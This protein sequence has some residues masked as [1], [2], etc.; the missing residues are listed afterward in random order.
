[1]PVCS[2]V[3]SLESP[4]PTARAFSP[5]TLTSIDYSLNPKIIAANPPAD[6][7]IER[8]GK[9]VDYDLPTLRGM[10]KANVNLGWGAR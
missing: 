10:N 5:H 7:T 3:I 8:I 1:V 4:E 9:L 2:F 6:V